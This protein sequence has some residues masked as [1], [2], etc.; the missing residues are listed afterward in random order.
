MSS[1]E[2]KELKSET[3]DEVIKELDPAERPIIVGGTNPSN[4]S[5]LDGFPITSAPV[6][7]DFIFNRTARIYFN[8]KNGDFLNY[9]IPVNLAIAAHKSQGELQMELTQIPQAMEYYWF[10]DLN[11][12][13]DF[14]KAKQLFHQMEVTHY[15]NFVPCPNTPTR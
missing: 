2:T 13:D 4:Y 3:V 9:L 7:W 6:Q 12:E 5:T 1:L 10:F 11:A 14:G 15:K 8:R